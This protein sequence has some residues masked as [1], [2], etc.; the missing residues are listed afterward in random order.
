MSARSIP[1]APGK[2]QR[3]VALLMAV[4]IA[5]LTTA[6]AATMIARLDLDIR[7]SETLF[8]GAQARAYGLGAERWA[9]QILGRD[10]D[11]SSIDHLGEPWARRIQPLP[12]EGGSLTGRIHDLQGRFNINALLDDQESANDAA[13]D[14]FRRLLANLDLDPQIVNAVLDWLDTD[15]KRRFPG[16][17]EDAFYMDRSPGY[18]TA[19]QR[20]VAVSELRLVKGVDREAFQAL[21]PHVSALP[22]STAINV[23]TATPEVLRAVAKGLGPGDAEALVEDR[24]EDGYGSVGDFGQHRALAGKDLPSGM[25]TVSSSYF[26]VEA[27]VNIGSTNVHLYSWLRRGG[28]KIRVISRSRASRY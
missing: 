12:L 22:G 5:A 7:R 24:G 17:A 8:H 16:G 1:K 23:N 28:D 2:R 9:A 26:L 4:L 14:I 15:Q 20:M 21:A 11:D 19:D 3:G 13:V 25:L 10:A 27:R 6:I 18:R